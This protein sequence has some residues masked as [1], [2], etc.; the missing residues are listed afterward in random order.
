MSKPFAHWNARIEEAA[1][2]K[3]QRELLGEIGVWR[4]SRLMDIPAQRAASY[5]LS[6][7]YAQLGESVQAAHEADQLL[8]LCRTSPE[9]SREELRFAQRHAAQLKKSTPEGKKKE[10]AARAK[11]A[12][13]LE[14]AASEGKWDE[15]LTALRGKRGPRAAMF[16]IWAQ[17]EKAM[18]QEGEARDAALQAL[19]ADL[20][21]RLLGGKDDAPAAAEDPGETSSALSAFLGRGVPKRRESLVKALE[22][23]LAANPDKSDALA[24]HALRH[25]VEVSGNRS[26]APWLF[27][28][29]ARALAGGPAKETR[30][31]L[32]ALTRDRAY[33]VTAY[34]EGP[35]RVLVDVWRE[36]AG[37]GATFGSLRRGVLGRNKEPADRRLWT[38]RFDLEGHER[39]VVVGPDWEAPYE[40]AMAAGLA[41]RI[42]D[43]GNRIVVAAPG[44][45]NAGFRAACVALRVSALDHTDA[46]AIVDGVVAARPLRKD[47]PK[48]EPKADR[49][50]EG[51]P[52]PKPEPKE[53]GPRPLDAIE[54]LF[55][56]DEVAAADAYAPHLAKLRRSFRAFAAVRGALNELEPAAAD[57]RA[58]PF[59]A[60]VHA[61]APEDVRLAEGA[62]VAV[63]LAA[64]V[65]G[66]EV[67]SLLLGDD[68]LAARFGGAGVAGLLSVVR[69]LPASWRVHRVLRGVTRRERR[70]HA[71]LDA[72]GDAMGGLWRLVVSDDAREGEVWFLVDPTPEAEAAV[73][74]LV[75]QDRPRAVYVAE[76][77]GAES[78]LA[79]AG[80]TGIALWSEDVAAGL[81]EVLAGWP[82]KPVKADAPA[83]T[84]PAEA[85]V[86]QAPAAPPVDASDV[87]EPSVEAAAPESSDETPADEAGA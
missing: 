70:E 54:A 1:D 37:R 24:A 49:K 39:L 17:F 55:R 36:A 75:Q 82:T 20:R 33:A 51:K 71:A 26:P 5:A 12:R 86:A 78:R 14:T 83:E 32:N 67:E 6:R 11:E 43:L 27:S 48:P 47:A 29:T 13:S 8:A 45:G 72:L 65:P 66:G 44:S 16:R 50:P 84:A 61:S 25:H 35:F 2:D 10:A 30:E 19:S 56:G 57:V 52:E 68:A 23:F 53:R 38:L 40:D 87:P 62:S 74:L 79:E 31:V 21:G 63:R 59:L 85:P 81:G 77:S 76:G 60:A 22:G 58:A 69:A 9:A 46:T 41:R 28:F 15:V 80:V 42:A 73:P 64:A 4:A 7:V 34:G 3:A 18:A